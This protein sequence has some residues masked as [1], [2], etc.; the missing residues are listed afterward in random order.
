MSEPTGDER[1]WAST[2][3]W[4][5]SPLYDRNTIQIWINGLRGRLVRGGQI[6][7]ADI[8][9]FV[10]IYNN[11]AQHQHYYDD[12]VGVDTFGN[13]AR[14]GGGHYVGRN[15]DGAGYGF[16]SYPAGAASHEPITAGVINQ[17]KGWINA[18]RSHSHGAADANR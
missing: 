9:M 13:Y 16:V 5:S 4:T 6:N 8:R 10:D 17:L 12:L 2:T 11:Y 14:Y 1:Y 18:L 3:R 15:T 7:A